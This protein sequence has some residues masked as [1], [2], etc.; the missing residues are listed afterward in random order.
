VSEAAAD[1]VRAR[2]VRLRRVAVG[3]AVVV[4]A[5]FV[6]I[7][8][9]LGNT[10]SEGVIFGPLDQVAMVLLGL[11]VAGGVLLLARPTVVA[12]L[13]GVR[14]R[15]I[16]STKDVPWEVVRAVSF[17]DGSPWAVLD[18][19][20]DDQISVLAVQASDGPRAVAAVRALREL[21]ARHAAGEGRGPSRRS[22]GVT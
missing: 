22:H 12:D 7:A 10:S 5:L 19:A 13:H 20:D 21:Q 17:P 11:L 2:P 9:L 1:V 14:V 16:F 15:N 8:V 6:L 3:I 18:L 4:V